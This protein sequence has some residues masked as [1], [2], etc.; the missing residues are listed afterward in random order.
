MENAKELSLVEKQ[1]RLEHILFR[2]AEFCEEN[3]LKYTLI[4]GTLLGAVRH[5]GFIPWDDDIDVGMPRPD[6]DRFVELASSGFGDGLE[7]LS[8][9]RDSR[10]TIAF[11]K[12]VDTHTRIDAEDIYYDGEAKSLWIDVLPFDGLGCDLSKAL[13]FKDASIKM[14]SKVGRA[15]SVPFKLRDGEHGIVGWLKCLYRFGYRLIGHEYFKEKLLK[16]ARTY[17]YGSSK[18]IA[19]FVMG[20]SG[21]GAV[22]EKEKFDL[23]NR[24]SFG[25]HMYR[26]MGCYDYNL[27]GLYGDYMQLPPEEKR[28]SPHL[29]RAYIV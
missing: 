4:W 20:K 11:T 27:S 1:E 22:I 14:Q 19:I 6:Y 10:L 16:A 3:N 26:A 9:D 25:G 23:E 15:A 5:Q 2:F 8:G 18:Y 7:I 24:L 12:V 17:D 29:S 21:L 28:V 13:K